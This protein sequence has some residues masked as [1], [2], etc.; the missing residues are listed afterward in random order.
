MTTIDL[1]REMLVREAAES[2]G[3]SPITI[4]R[5]YREG[6]LRGRKE[7]G[8]ILIDRPSVGVY[9]ASHL[10]RRGRRQRPKES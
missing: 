8:I 1:S 10:G 7:G 4:R 9:R 2:L 3:L 5:A 6:R